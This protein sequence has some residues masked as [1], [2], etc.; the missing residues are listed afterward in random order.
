M[1]FLRHNLLWVLYSQFGF[2]Q[3]K[4]FAPWDSMWAFKL[5]RFSS[6]F[7]S[8]LRTF[9]ISLLRVY[10]RHVN[11]QV[12]AQWSRTNIKAPLR[13]KINM[14]ISGN[15]KCSSV[16]ILQEH[17]FP[18]FY[19]N[20]TIS[21]PTK[22]SGNS[23]SPYGLMLKFNISVKRQTPTNTNQRPTLGDNPHA[24]DLFYVKICCGNVRISKILQ[25]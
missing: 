24:V 17:I 9:E 2:G 18:K 13:W 22:N 11:F 23:E 3:S 21:K 10:I 7:A 16:T 8:V 6:V 15:K 5:L 4:V 12:V 1:W 14:Q 20:W 25:N 19:Q